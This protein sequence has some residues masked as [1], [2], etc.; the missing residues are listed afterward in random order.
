MLCC[1]GGHHGSAQAVSSEPA[2]DDPHAAYY[3]GINSD[4]KDLKQQ[5]HALIYRTRKTLT[6]NDAW[7]GFL[8]TGR[9]LPGYPCNAAEPTWIADVYS[10]KCW[11]QSEQCGNYKKEGD[12]YNREHIWPKSWFGGTETAGHGAYTDLFELYPSDGYVNGLRSNDPLGYVAPGQIKYTSSNG[13][14]LGP[15]DG[16]RNYG[17]STGNCFELPDNL[18][19]K[20]E[21]GWMVVIPRLMP[22]C[23]IL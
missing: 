23:L 10:G 15:C 20:C 2:S 14:H 3:A 19:G 22:L 18:K 1:S 7:S 8:D 4:A 13:C 11:S 5:L 6:Y 21:V 17:H 9:F 16:A 12:C